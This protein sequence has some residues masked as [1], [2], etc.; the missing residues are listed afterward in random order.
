M[1]K[2]KNKKDNVSIEAKTPNPMIYV[3]PGARDSIL[4]TFAIFAYGI[5]EEYVDDPIFK[6]LFVPPAKLDSAR[7]AVGQK[8]S[9]LNTFYH[10][11]D[12][13]LKGANK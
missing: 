5:P 3:G 4:S 2:P 9:A 12:E 6:H 1:V 10:K 8:G 13:I 11:A 7:K